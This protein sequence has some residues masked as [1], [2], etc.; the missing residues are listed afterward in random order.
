MKKVTW[1]IL[2]MILALSLIQER[3]AA[4]GQ[5]TPGGGWSEPAGGGPS[6]GSNDGPAKEAPGSK[7]DPG[8]RLGSESG[9]HAPEFGGFTLGGGSHVGA[10]GESYSK[11]FG[12]SRNAEPKGTPS[13]NGGGGPANEPRPVRL[14]PPPEPA[15][16][17]TPAFSPNPK[18]PFDSCIRPPVEG[19]KPFN[20]APQAPGP[21]EVP[22][23]TPDGP[24]W[25]EP[26][27]GRPPVQSPVRLPAPEVL[28]C[29]A[30]GDAPPLDDLPPGSSSR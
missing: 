16:A 14:D 15:R 24:H 27:T 9:L 11:G 1:S 26:P 19:D 22:E 12:F 13:D 25:W 18:C 28:N 20:Y 21:D 8:G 7:A 10:N 29:V 2:A 4:F 6:G 3:A 5:D 17:P 23:L 30:S